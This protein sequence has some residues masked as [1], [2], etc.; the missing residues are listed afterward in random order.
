MPGV[1]GVGV[2]VAGV[3]SEEGA[4]RADGVGVVGL[5]STAGVEV[6]EGWE[7]VGKEESP[8]DAGPCEDDMV[9]GGRGWRIGTRAVVVNSYV[10]KLMRLEQGQG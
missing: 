10:A 9:E 4:G 1:V 8:A 7:D 2:V 5:D 6:F 3:G